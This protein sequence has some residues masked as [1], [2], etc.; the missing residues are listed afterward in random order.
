MQISKLHQKINKKNNNISLTLFGSIIWRDE[1]ARVFANGSLI[2][3]EIDE[4]ENK[5][6]HSYISFVFFFE[7]DKRKRQIGENVLLFDQEKNYY[8]LGT[9]LDWK[10]KVGLFHV[11]SE[12][13]EYWLSP[14]S[15]KST[16]MQRLKRGTCLL[17]KPQDFNLTYT[18]SHL[19]SFV[20]VGCT[21]IFC[22][23]YQTKGF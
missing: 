21:N 8:T 3:D 1:P 12:K 2:F 16:L 4:R 6:E 11:V 18:H 7:P 23:T 17:L 13:K 10:E 15:G 9:I 22:R 19:S 20:S 14:D 5:T